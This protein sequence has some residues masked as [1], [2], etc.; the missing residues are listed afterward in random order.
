MHDFDVN[1]TVPYEVSSEC[2]QL[3]RMQFIQIVRTINKRILAVSKDGVFKTKNCFM[4][5][6]K[7]N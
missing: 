2:I 6:N 3:Y 5:V 1:V 4:G 7:Y